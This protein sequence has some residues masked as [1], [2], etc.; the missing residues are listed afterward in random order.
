MKTRD[1]IAHAPTCVKEFGFRIWINAVR[2]GL[3]CWVRGEKPQLTTFL[4]VQALLEE[5]RKE[6]RSLP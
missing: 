5:A 4:I 3:G 1:L 2:Y 6:E